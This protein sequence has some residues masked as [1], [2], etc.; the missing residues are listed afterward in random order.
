MVGLGDIPGGQFWSFA[1]AVTND[2]TVIVGSSWGENGTEAFRWTEETGMVGL[3]MG[4]F[5]FG[6]GPF[7]DAYAVSDD[8][9]IVVGMG[10]GY[11]AV[12]WDERHGFRSIA[13][14]LEGAGIDL[15]GWRLEQ[16]RGVSADGLT[17]VGL[18]QNPNGQQES[19]VTVLPASAFD[20]PEPHS[21]ALLAICIVVAMRAWGESITSTH[22]TRHVPQR[23][24][25]PC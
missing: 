3:G 12:V 2:G 20:V 6:A 8:G 25:L 9:S 5:H 21:L 23:H 13:R 19:W 17:I 10:T 7:S 16:A 18:G 1:T 22:P 4:P 14:L 24:R 11:Q 15:T